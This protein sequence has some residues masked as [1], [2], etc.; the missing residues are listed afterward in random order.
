MKSPLLYYN[1]FWG[2]LFMISE[3]RYS[4][5]EIWII[6]CQTWVGFNCITPE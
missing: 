6:L 3:F 2:L 5:I 4:T 1:S